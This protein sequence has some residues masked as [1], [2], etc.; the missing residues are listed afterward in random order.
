MKKTKF[1]SVLTLAIALLMTT[2]A[3]G[4]KITSIRIATPSWE[5]QTNRDGS[6]LIFD[7]V[8]SVYEPVGIKMDYKL[9]PWK[10]AEAMLSSN[11]ADA[12]L[13]ARKRKDRLTPEYPMW[14]EYT[15]AV[16]RKDNITAWSGI[17][18]LEGR[19]AIWLRGYDFHTDDKMKPVY[20]KWWGE[21]DAY[22]QGWSMLDKG[23]TDFFIDALVDIN[24]YIKKSRVDMSPYRIEILWG[25]PSYMSFAETG[26]AEKLMKIYDKRIIELF[27]SGELKKLFDKWDIRYSP[28]AW[29]K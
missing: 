4:E 25:E 5:S 19:K 26:K 27:K 14:T 11:R 24:Q 13:S 18:T 9:V 22:A 2:S 1:I 6:G 15:A 10:R 3:F 29:Q 16:F 7:I 28:E 20:L 12:M 21:V 23:R 8:R 17:K